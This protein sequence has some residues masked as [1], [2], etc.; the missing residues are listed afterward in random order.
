MNELDLKVSAGLWYEDIRKSTNDTFMPLYAVT[1][2]H[3][4]LVGGAGS[5]KSIFAGRKILERITSEKGHRILVC[6]KIARTLRESCFRQLVEQI[7]LHYD[8]N[9]FKINRTDM[10]ITY[11]PN[12]SQ[13]LFAGLDDVEKLKSIYHVTGIWI[14][15]GSELAE[16]DYNQ[17]NIRLRGKTAHYKQMITTFNPV[18]INHWLKRRF[19]NECIE[20][21]TTHKSTYRDNRFLDAEQKK[22]L[23]SFKDTDPYY[24]QVYCLGE[25]GVYGKTIFS[26]TIISLWLQSIQDP[27]ATGHFAYDYD[28]LS[29]DNIRWIDDENGYIKLY[30]SPQ[31]DHPYVIGCDTAGEGSDY[32]TAQVLDNT[33]G[34][35]VAVLRQGFDEDVFAKQLYCLGR[36]YNEALIGIEANFTTYPIRELERLGYTK[37][38]IRETEDNFTHKVKHAYGFKTTALTRPIILADLVR[39]VREDCGL[40]NDRMTLEEMLTFVRNEKGRAEAQSGAHDDLIMALAIAHYIRSQQDSMIDI[41]KPKKKIN[42][43]CEEAPRD[44]LGSGEAISVI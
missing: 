25:W 24:Y 1:D 35:Q 7:R 3:L 33:N 14:E 8:Y 23:E 38:Y 34:E 43:A 30:Y 17:L 9:A 36:Y 29:I 13:I 5:G 11:L 12:N 26:A 10:L 22:V 27:I 18:D 40:I 37:Q 39:I 19:F 44:P 20:D 21:V 31:N 41:F 28:G 2:R 4:V 6:R 32:F 15:E 16:N 42:F